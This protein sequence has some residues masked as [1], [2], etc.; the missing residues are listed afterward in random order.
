MGRERRLTQR[1][2]GDLVL[3]PSASALNPDARDAAVQAATISRARSPRTTERRPLATIRSK[4]EGQ[5]CAIRA[6][7]TAHEPVAAVDGGQPKRALTST[8]LLSNLAAN[9]PYPPEKRK[10]TGSTPVP[11]TRV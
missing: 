3:D 4:T 6:R 1:V 8:V 11:T 7:K 9:A 5:P 10:V 2:V